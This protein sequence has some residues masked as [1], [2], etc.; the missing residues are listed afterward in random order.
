[1]RAVRVDQH[2]AVSRVVGK[3]PIFDGPFR[4]P[5]AHQ[6]E[7]AERDIQR[8]GQRLHLEFHGFVQLPRGDPYGVLLGRVENDHPQRS[9][10]PGQHGGPEDLAVRRRQQIDR[11]R[12]EHPHVAGAAEQRARRYGVEHRPVVQEF[13]GLAGPHLSGQCDAI[14]EQADS[15]QQRGPPQVVGQD[16][17]DE[18]EKREH[19]HDQ[20]DRVCVNVLPGFDVAHDSAPEPHSPILGANVGSAYSHWVSNLEQDPKETLSGADPCGGPARDILTGHEVALGGPRGMLVTRTLPNRARRMVG[21]WCFADHYGPAGQAMRVAPHPHTGLQTV[22]WLVEGQVRHR[23]SLGSDQLVRPG[24][25]NLMTAGRGIAHAEESPALGDAGDTGDA[26]DTVLHG[27]QLWVALPDATRHQAPAFDHHADLPVVEVPGAR[28]TVIM[29]ALDGAVSPAAAHTPILGAEIL[30]SGPATLPLEE[31]FEHAA[32]VLSGAVEVDGTA[33]RP[34]PLLYLGIGRSSLRLG[35]EGRV[36]LLGGEPFEE[37]IVMWWNFVGRTHDE[38]LTFRKEWESSREPDTSP[39]FDTSGTKHA[40]GTIEPSGIFGPVEFD[41]AALPAP[42]LP[43]ARLKPR[44]RLG[45]P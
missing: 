41:G 5:F 45:R 37:E 18:P 20:G 33:L 34:G 15:G 10:A 7:P 31:G 17:A 21:A 42:A 38:I 4:L 13:R 26:A 1:M 44:G 11:R 29:G 6:A 36:L 28:A 39:I 25:L 9:A 30:V 32:L 27:V 14:D 22:T 2:E 16:V 12:R 3:Q 43:T 19:E 24:Q 40:S 35:G 8:R 23:D